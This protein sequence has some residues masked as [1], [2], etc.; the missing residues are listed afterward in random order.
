[1]CINTH[2]HLSPIA[3]HIWSIHQ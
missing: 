1:M 3:I 2:Y